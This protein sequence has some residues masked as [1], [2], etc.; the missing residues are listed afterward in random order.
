MKS[1]VEAE[2]KKTYQVQEIQLDEDTKRH[3]NG[4]GIIKGSKIALISLAGESGIILSQSARLALS[5]K[6]LT[7]ILV[8]E[9]VESSETWLSLDMLAVGEKAKVLRI[10][11]TG[12]IKRRLMDMG[13]TKGTELLVQKVAPLADPIEIKVRGYELSLRKNEAAQVLVRKELS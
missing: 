2:L 8:D 12:A 13:L 4:L 9:T 5:Q 10:Y 7:G 1:L 3:L 11:G 6:V